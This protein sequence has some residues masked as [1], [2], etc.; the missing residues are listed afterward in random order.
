MTN[1]A[2]VPSLSTEDAARRLLANI[3]ASTTGSDVARRDGSASDFL[4]R[5]LAAH[6]VQ[7][8]LAHVEFAALRDVEIPCL[9]SA[10]D[11]R[12]LLLT[13]RRGL[14]WVVEDERGTSCALSSERL[15]EIF[16]GLALDRI[17]E[18]PAGAS[19][20]S[21]LLRL[22]WSHRRAFYLTAL[23]ALLAQGLSLVVPQLAR[24]LVDRALPD[25]ATNLLWAIVCGML[26]VAV[27]QAW[28][29]WLER[30][31]A[32]SLQTRLDALLERGMLAHVMQMPYEFLEKKSFGQLLQ[33]FQG[34]ATARDLLTGEVLTAALGGMTATAFLVLMARQMAAPTVLVA[35]VGGLAMAV[36][37]LVGRRQ[38]AVQQHFVEALTREREYA[39]EIFTHIAMFK[40]AGAQ[41][42]GVD[43]WLQEFRRERGLALREERLGL[44]SHV[45]LDLLGQL[46]FQGLWIWGGWCVLQGSLQLGELIAFTLMAGAFHAALGNLGR[47]VVIFRTVR[48]L[49]HETQSLL[50]QTP[51]PRAPAITRSAAGGGSIEVR[52]LWFRHGADLPWIFSGLD[53]IVERGTFHRIDGPSGFGK[54]TLLRLIG[55]LYQPQRGSIC[56][57]GRTPH[58]ARELMA[59]LP[60]FV[61]L[62]NASIL[63]NLRLFSGGMPN[64]ALMAAAE[65]TGLAMLVEDL[66][67]GYD[68]LLAQGG[69]NFSAGQR[70]LIAL[71]GVLAAGKPILL[72]DEAMANMDSLRRAALSQSPLLRDKTIVCASHDARGN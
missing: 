56:V 1:A 26:L 52:D 38:E 15:A 57:A 13:G 49:L 72:F 23:F 39:A 53:L 59:Y 66:P 64:A 25:G 16:D 2:L 20:S 65:L 46:Q 41:D 48:P 9:L 7:A 27:M 67:M 47:T 4:L 29:N 6:G 5:L 31:V 54:T 22:A 35:A 24:V 21:R 60:Q 28:T 44:V 12:W 30:R 51:L 63:D 42:R 71:T 32:Q 17:A 61:Q 40:A 33:A 10:Q 3:G 55:G 8:R 58:E 34:I 37:I 50:A 70:Q 19:L 11:A 45:I 14:G 18:L 43:R 36:T 62:F 69:G 68:T